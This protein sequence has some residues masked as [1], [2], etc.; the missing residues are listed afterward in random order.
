MFEH[1]CWPWPTAERKEQ[2]DFHE[3]LV[4]HTH[5][6]LQ[7]EAE[8]YRR[9]RVFLNTLRRFTH[10]EEET[11][12]C[13]AIAWSMREEASSFLPTMKLNRA[14]LLKI[15]QLAVI[16]CS[17][18]AA[19]LM[20]NLKPSVHFASGTKKGDDTPYCLNLPVKREASSDRPQTRLEIH[21][22]KHRRDTLEEL[23]TPVV[24]V[25]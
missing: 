2:Q 14:N 6:L 11:T 20:A 9:N 15:P 22:E 3:E 10:P 19:K 24:K 25:S 17:M 4:E 21:V 7:R 1:H 8:R 23:R 12:F 5:F 13:R 18:V 16:F